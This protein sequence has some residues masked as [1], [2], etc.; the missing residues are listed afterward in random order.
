MAA[1]RRENAERSGTEEAL[2]GVALTRTASRLSFPYKYL[3]VQLTAPRQLEAGSPAN[4][5]E[6]SSSQ[7]LGTELGV[8]S[9]L[10]V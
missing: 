3:L 1:A 10:R 6:S 9:T 7:I 8:L 4:L 5:L 2:T